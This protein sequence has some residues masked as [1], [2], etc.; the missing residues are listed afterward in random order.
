[1][2]L[3]A[4]SILDLNLFIQECWKKQF[5]WDTPLPPYLI[6]RWLKLIDLT[7]TR[8]MLKM[9]NEAKVILVSP[10]PRRLWEFKKDGTICMHIFYD[11]S[12]KA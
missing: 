5:Q 1:M 7:V 3:F 11:A 4:P 9:H 6:A 10:I 8:S 2:G 12:E